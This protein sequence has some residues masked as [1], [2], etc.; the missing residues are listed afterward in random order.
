MEVLTKVAQFVLSL[1]ILV[2]VHEF[3]HF[4][5]ARLFKVRVDKF[6]LFFD[7]WFSLFKFKPKGGETEYGV[8]WL[9]LGGYCKISGMIDE[10]MDKEQLAQAPQPWEFRSKPA[11]MRLLILVAG[12]LLNFL[13]ALLIF[14]MILFKWG[15]SYLPLRNMQMG[16][17]YSDT[18]K[19]AGFKDG[20]II[21]DAD[22]K[23]LERLN[24]GAIRAVIE[25]KTVTVMRDGA[26]FAIDMPKGM[27]Q[28]MLAGKQAFPSP[29]FPMIVQ[30]LADE[31][32]PA[33]RAGLRP[34][35]R[36]VSI[37]GVPAPTYDDVT[38]LLGKNK[39]E[40]VQVGFLRD[41]AA[42]EAPLA[43]GADGKMGVYVKSYVDLYQTVHVTYGFLDSFP[44]GIRLGWDTLTGYV[45][46]M[47]YVFT[48]EGA[49]SIGGFGTIA[50]QFPS[51]W[52]WRSFWMMTAFLSI[53]LAFMNILPIPALDG[54]H[55]LFILYEIVTRRRPSEKFLVYAQIAGMALLLGLM[56]Y[57]NGNDV[58]KL[59]GK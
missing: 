5:F 25:A 29:R 22:G 39:G 49:S 14:S 58:F 2:L 9:P 20:D 56:L 46:D 33:A 18:F 37:D 24:S 54:G 10:S 7:P 23:D 4:V 34:G 35:D 55:V 53:I 8:G 17:K 57:A 3:G 26:P 50:S 36:I 28:R 30:K 11:W 40:T 38:E 47:K 15:D 21:L 32:V 45:G 13:S 31:T 16:L 42:L 44:A 48:K 1:S 43:V 19:D 59:L 27:M 6:Y 52:D 12:V 51:M 41:G